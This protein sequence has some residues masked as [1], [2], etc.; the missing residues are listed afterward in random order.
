MTQEPV[1]EPRQSRSRATMERLLVAAEAI[2]EEKSWQAL[3][4]QD[5]VQQAGCSV[6]AF[7]GRFKDKNGLLHALDERYFE[8]IS[9]AIEATISAL[10]STD[11]SLQETVSALA[12]LVVQIHS[13]NQGVM[14]TVILQARLV[15]D[16]RFRTREAQL[17]QYRAKIMALV[18]T[19]R[20]RIA[21]EDTETAALFGYLQMYY[22]AREM[23][24]WPHLS[25]AMPYQG[26]ALATA[27]AESYYA[28]LVGV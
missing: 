6:G 13:H 9:T 15:A 23:M 10:E 19:H 8:D 12:T 20:Q 25:A 18:L 11:H 14:R 2:L 1:K 7:Y 27:L 22:T 4:I 28:Y 5:V 16:P 17:M 3:T 24:L 26:E 21:H